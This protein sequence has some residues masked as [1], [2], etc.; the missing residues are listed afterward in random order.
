MITLLLNRLKIH[1]DYLNV[2]DHN[3]LPT[4]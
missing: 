2:C 1:Y 3:P 4:L